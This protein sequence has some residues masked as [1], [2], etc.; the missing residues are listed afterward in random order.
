MKGQSPV[1]M[2]L[3]AGIGWAI[4]LPVVGVG[5]LWFRYR[6]C[7]DALKPGKLWDAMLWISFVGFLVV[8]VVA[9][10]KTIG[11]VFG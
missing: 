1:A 2:V 9:L 5:A 7:V 4:L 10:I 8:G 3:A 6:R 11:K